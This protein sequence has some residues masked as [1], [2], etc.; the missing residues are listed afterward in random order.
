[1][2]FV[3]VI[4]ALNEW[5]HLDFYI[6]KDKNRNKAITFQITDPVLTTHLAY[7]I[8]LIG[9]KSMLKEEN[10]ELVYRDLLL[11]NGNTSLVTGKKMKDEEM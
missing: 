10:F 4:R 7:V 8:N 11:E 6:D 3:D 9:M 5:E 2:D 1:M